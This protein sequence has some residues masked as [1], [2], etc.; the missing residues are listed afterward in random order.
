MNLKNAVMEKLREV[1]DPEV[2]L[3]IVEMGLIKD[4]LIDVEGKVKIKMSLT[5]PSFMCPLA[6]YLVSSVKKA[7]ESV[8]GVKEVEVELIEPF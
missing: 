6:K 8:E 1:I 2:G 3:S 4:V 5:V 7:A